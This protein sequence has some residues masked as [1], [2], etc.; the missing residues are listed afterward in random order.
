[1]DPFVEV[2]CQEIELKTSVK[3][4][5]GKNPVWNETLTFEFEEVGGFMNIKVMD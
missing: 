1:M 3:Q 2:K 4:D 5:A